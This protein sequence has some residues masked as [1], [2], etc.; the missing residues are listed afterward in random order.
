MSD[1][2]SKTWSDTFRSVFVYGKEH[3]SPK[4]Y[5]IIVQKTFI[6]PRRFDRRNMFLEISRKGC[7]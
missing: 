7:F 4:T 1:F 6:F 5:F 2:F 3:E